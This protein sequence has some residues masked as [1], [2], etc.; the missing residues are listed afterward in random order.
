M[1]PK[2][3]TRKE[4]GNEEQVKQRRSPNTGSRQML[5]EAT[6]NRDMHK[7]RNRY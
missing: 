1:H 5:T 4:Q 6:R 2:E 3:E 7:S